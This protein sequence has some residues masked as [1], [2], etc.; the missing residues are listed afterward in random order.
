MSDGS[1][2]VNS[3]PIQFSEDSAVVRAEESLGLRAR[4]AETVT[5]L[6]AGEDEVAFPYEEQLP[7]PVQPV[8]QAQLALSLLSQTTMAGFPPGRIDGMSQL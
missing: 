5:L 2:S 1:H 8:N 6:N 7:P 3:E 4:P